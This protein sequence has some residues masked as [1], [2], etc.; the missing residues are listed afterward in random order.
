MRRANKYH[1]DSPKKRK[2]VRLPNSEYLTKGG[3]ATRVNASLDRLFG[4]QMRQK[5]DPNFTR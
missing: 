2:R 1:D 4:P 5:Y 3:K